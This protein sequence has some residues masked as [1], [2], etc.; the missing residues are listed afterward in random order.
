MARLTSRWFRDNNNHHVLC[1]IPHKTH[2]IHLI[3]VKINYQW[4]VLLLHRTSSN[5]YPIQVVSHVQL[6]AWPSIPN[7]AM[8][9]NKTSKQVS[10]NFGNNSS[11]SST[12]RCNTI[13]RRTYNTR[14]R[15]LARQFLS[16]DSLFI[17]CKRQTEVPCSAFKWSLAWLRLCLRPR[18]ERISD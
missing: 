9:S 4:L 8:S 17:P 13:G 16:I 7:L 11:I 15:W 6:A 14:S 18:N 12:C 10:S 5:D 2:I 1:Q 3:L